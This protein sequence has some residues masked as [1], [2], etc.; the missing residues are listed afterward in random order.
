M[1]YIIN[2][3]IQRGKDENIDDKEFALLYDLNASEN[4]EFPSW[5][6][7]RL[8]LDSMTDDECKAKSRCFKNDVYLLGEV[9]DIPDIM[10]CPDYVL[11]DGTEALSGLL[12]RFAYPCRFADIVARLGRPVPQPCRLQTE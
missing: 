11:V 8:D 2:G 6:Y 1:L 10:K 4:L 9:L 3:K 5:T 12:K 7:V